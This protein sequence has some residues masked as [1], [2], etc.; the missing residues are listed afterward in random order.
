MNQHLTDETIRQVQEVLDNPE[1]RE[2]M[3]NHNFEIAKRYYSYTVL[4][5][6]LR[7]LIEDF[8]GVF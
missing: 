6:H 5:R 7:Y 1:I 4:R 2:A 8:F 3:V